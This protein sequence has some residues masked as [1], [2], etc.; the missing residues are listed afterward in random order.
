MTYD[1]QKRS[2]LLHIAGMEVQEVYF[3]LVGKDTMATFQD[4]L[5]VLDDYFIPKANVRFE[6]HLFWQITQ[7][8]TETVDQFVCR[9]RHRSVSCDFR[10]Q[11]DD[12][13]FAIK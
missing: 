13:I 12:Y 8:N 10:E 5:K 6:R 2:L 3:T 7:E 9:L 11:E 4:T 1:L